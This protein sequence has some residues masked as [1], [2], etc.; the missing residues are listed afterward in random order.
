M[1][2]EDFV[3]ETVKDMGKLKQRYHRN[4]KANIEN[5]MSSFLRSYFAVNYYFS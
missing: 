2:Q 3:G 5:F 4:S 1:F